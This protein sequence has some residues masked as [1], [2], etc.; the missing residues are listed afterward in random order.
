MPATSRETIEHLC[1]SIINRLENKKVI[2]LE[3]EKRSDLQ[4]DMANLI[5]PHIFTEEDLKNKTLEM[6]GATN[7]M[8]LEEGFAETSN[9]R[10]ARSM[11][12]KSF[13]DDEL[14]GFYFQKSLREIAKMIAE[15]FMKSNHV[16]DVFESDH[17]IVLKI[18]DIVK[19]FDQKQLH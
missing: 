3:S 11:V 7:D 8:M 14:N 10:T 4:T 9:Y 2:E 15:F 17:D 5:S 18:V 16:E 1:K 12:R 6:L 13:G 19:K